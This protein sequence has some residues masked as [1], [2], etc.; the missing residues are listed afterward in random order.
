MVVESNN[1]S[2]NFFVEFF[3]NYPIIV[4]LILVFRFTYVINIIVKILVHKNSMELEGLNIIHLLLII[5]VIV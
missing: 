5:F 2:R 1:F 4:L 3:K